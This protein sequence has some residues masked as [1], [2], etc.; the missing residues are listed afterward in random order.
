MW[1]GLTLDICKGSSNY[2]QL[3]AE[4][5]A[6]DAQG[7]ENLPAPKPATNGREHQLCPSKEIMH[8][9]ARSLRAHET[10]ELPPTT[11]CRH[12]K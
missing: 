11:K 10:S 9:T 4:S 6:T 8:L 1:K 2:H 5:L 3:R 12:M 7:E